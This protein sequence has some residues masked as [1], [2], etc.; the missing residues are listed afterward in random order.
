VRHIAVAAVFSL[1]S[2]VSSQPARA[3]ELR[4]EY[5]RVT[6]YTLSGVMADAQPVHKGAAACANYMPL[7]TRLRFNDGYVVTCEDR[8]FGGSIW[9]GWVDIWAPSRAWGAANVTDAYGDYTWVDVLR[10]GW[11]DG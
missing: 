5:V 7:G 2:A 4:Q 9:D 3:Q 10:W 11:G 6:F 1:S 8:G